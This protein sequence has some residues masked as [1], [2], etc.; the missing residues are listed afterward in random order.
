MHDAEVGFNA[1]LI[2]E[3]DDKFNDSLVSFRGFGKGDVLV[4]ILLVVKANVSVHL[5]RKTQRNASS[6]ALTGCIRHFKKLVG[7]SSLV[8]GSTIVENFAPLE[9]L[10]IRS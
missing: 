1:L 4:K 9:C 5:L 10:S 6:D 3:M 8:S 7:V 2:R